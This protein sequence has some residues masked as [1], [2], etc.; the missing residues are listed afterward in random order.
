MKLVALFYICLC[1][2]A[3]IFAQDTVTPSN[4]SDIFLF[5][6]YWPL[7]ENP[8]LGKAWSLWAFGFAIGGVSSMGRY[9]QWNSCV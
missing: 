8:Q 3:I 2:V 4:P 7:L 9:I 1:F 6:E 5:G